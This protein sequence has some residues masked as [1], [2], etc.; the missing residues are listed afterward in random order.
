MARR[1]YTVFAEINNGIQRFKHQLGSEWSFVPDK[2]ICKQITMD[3]INKKLYVKGQEFQVKWS[4]K[5]VINYITILPRPDVKDYPTGKRLHSTPLFYVGQYSPHVSSSAYKTGR[6]HYIP[7]VN[8]TREM[9]AKYQQCENSHKTQEGH[10]PDGL[11][12]NGGMAATVECV[13]DVF[14]TLL[15]EFTLQTAYD[16]LL[17]VLLTDQYVNLDPAGI[18]AALLHIIIRGVA[19]TEQLR[20]YSAWRKIRD[21]RALM[22]LHVLFK[23]GGVN[24]CSHL[25]VSSLMHYMHAETSLHRKCVEQELKLLRIG[26]HHDHTKFQPLMRWYYAWYWGVYQQASEVNR[27]RMLSDK[28][29]T[30]EEVFEG[31]ETMFRGVGSSLAQGIAESPELRETVKSVAKDVISESTAQFR[32]DMRQEFNDIKSEAAELLS[33]SISDVKDISDETIAKSS[34]LVEK[35]TNSMDSITTMMDSIRNM[36]SGFLQNCMS[37]FKALP[38]MSDIKINL[39]SILAAIRDWIMYINVDSSVLKSILIISMLNNLG[40]LKSGFQ[41]IS[42]LWDYLKE[43]QTPTAEIDGEEVKAEETSFNAIFSFMSGSITNLIQVIAGTT[44][45]IVNGGLI[46]ATQFWS[47]CEHLS[48]SLKTVH[49]IGAGLMGFSRI[50]DFVSKI[51]TSVSDWI[52]R[53]LFKKTPE[54]EALARKVM[55]WVVKVKYFSTEAGLD[56]IRLNKKMR[57]TA[58]SLYAEYVAL[59]ISCRE[60]PEYR[61]LLSDIERHKKQIVDIYDYITR[62]E[63]VSNFCPTMFHIQFVGEPGVGKSFLFKTFVDNIAQTLWPEDVDSSFYSY[64]PNL[65]FF[66]GYAGQRIFYIDDCFRM[67][68]PKHLTQLIGLVTNTP[69]I[70]PMA[71]LADKG[72]QLTSDVMVS[73]TNTAWPIGKD[74]LCMEAVHRRRHMLVEVEIDPRVRDSSTGAFSMPLYKKYYKEEDLSK[75]PHLKFNMLRP[76]PKDLEGYNKYQTDSADTFEELKQFAEELKKANVRVMTPGAEKLS[77]DTDPQFFFS[78]DNK[79]PEGIKLPCTGWTYE[80]MIHNFIVRYRAFR[81]LERTYSTQR[82]YAHAERA[83]MEI[84]AALYQSEDI[85]T[86]DAV[87]LP[88][89]KLIEK[90]FSDVHHPYGVSDPIGQKIAE[91][92]ESDQVPDLDH[93]DFEKMVDE[94]LQEKKETMMSLDHETEVIRSIRNRVRRMKESEPVAMRNALRLI[95]IN[96]ENKSTTYMPLLSDYTVWD[97]YSHVS[98]RSKVGFF[99]RNWEAKQLIELYNTFMLDMSV[100]QNES[101]LK[102]FWQCK[103]A[104][105]KFQQEM[106]KFIYGSHSYYPDREEFG[107]KR[108][109]KTSFPLFFLQRLE[110][111]FGQW[112]LDVSDLDHFNKYKLEANIR[113][114][115]MAHVKS[116]EGWYKVPIDTAFLFSLSDCFRTFVR[117][118]YSLSEL[119]QDLIVQDAKWRNIYTGRYTFASIRES[120]SSTILSGCVRAAEYLLAPIH[121]LF[122]KAPFIIE[123]AAKTCLFAVAIW[124]LRSVAR[125]MCGTEET[126]KYL[127]RGPQSNI[128]YRGRT[129]AHTTT[130]SEQEAGNYLKKNIFQLTIAD[131][132]SGVQV[133]GLLFKQYIV[134]NAHAIRGFKDSDLV[135]TIHTPQTEEGEEESRKI[136]IIPR[137]NFYIHEDG[138]LA[139]G[140]SRQLPNK[141]DIF[142]QF[143]SDEEFDRMEFSNSD[144]LLL[145]R[146]QNQPA[147]EFHPF[148]K[149][150]LKPTLTIPKTQQKAVLD[151]ALILN[152]H[153]IVGKSG[154]TALFRNNQGNFRI[155]GIQAW[156]IGGQYQPQIAVQVITKELLQPL[157]DKIELDHKPIHREAEYHDN[158]T[159]DV[160]IPGAFT[161]KEFNNVIH[162]LPKNEAAGTVGETQF[163]GTPISSFMDQDGHTSLR[164]PAALNP[165]DIRLY[166]KAEH[167]LKHS[168]GKY[169]RGEIQPFPPSLLS[170]IRKGVGAWIRSKLDKDS[171]RRLEPH[172]IITGTREDGSNPMNLSSSPG[173]PFI[174][175]KKKKGKRDFF[176]IDDEG[177]VCF[178][179]HQTYLDYTKFASHLRQRKLPL[180]RAYDFPKD[181]L[182]PIS[183]A[184][185]TASSPPKTRT[186]TCMNMFHV[187]AWREVT[188]DFWASMHRAADGTFPFCPGINPEGPEWSAAFHYLNKHPNAIDFD[189]SNWDGFLPADLLYLAGDIVADVSELSQEDRN[190]VDSILFDVINC[191]IQ[192]DRYIYQKFRGMVSGFPGTAEM[193]TLVH[194]LLL[195]CIYLILTQDYPQYHSIEAFRYHVSF[196]VYGD[197]IIITFSDEIS[198]IFNGV[199]IAKTYME[200][201]YPVTSADKSQA[202]H[203]AK[204]LRDC[205]FLKSTWTRMFQGV[206]V[207]KMDIEVAYDL[208]YW[209]RAK[210]HPVQQF[211]IN[212]VDALRIVFGH[213]EKRFD[214]FVKQ[215]NG[216]LKRA[217]LEPV[218]YTYYDFYIDYVSRY[219]QISVW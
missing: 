143:M 158:I 9:I 132:S 29:T 63:A 21:Q 144:M 171:F 61:V 123:W 7:P 162:L 111:R 78:E 190:V 108:K 80:Q 215:L 68:E 96:E 179:D 218:L 161:S 192:Y 189:V 119:Q 172:E 74:V 54:I 166:N 34:T 38:G 214:A 156:S 98:S 124:A 125:L 1:K 69:V 139:V 126:S 44:A 198:S 142:N 199:S 52:S 60:K 203:A 207:R 186:V 66:D 107:D 136:F 49:F 173:I 148:V 95:T 129:T 18:Y 3:Y 16:K 208:L 70:L 169:F 118:F 39:D 216:W 30:V 159:P 85:D 167:P 163:T 146:F 200:I 33:K 89:T 181:E 25:M 155:A 110:K 121:F 196:L 50:F 100:N 219:Y 197:D 170:Y 56:A 113:Y 55:L 183:K 53:V 191:N 177:N 91:S 213:G 174:F 202:I 102:G 114:N 105:F 138:D 188:L 67:Q 106:I 92:P 154:S 131:S 112:A 81:G 157:L 135:V 82:K 10:H 62:L 178:F 104:G 116:G 165:L 141:R 5:E 64:N 101:F 204:S 160:Y 153:T 217:N 152:G 47:L 11:G 209:V 23:I 137:S 184:L 15:R 182:R 20:T 79:P 19:S 87:T 127:H 65:E 140:Y 72:T 133:Q 83:L 77:P 206:Y 90:W 180:T 4:R 2:S 149:V 147:M 187:M 41:F 84:D 14:S 115:P 185:G 76:V 212:V 43:L 175:N 205:Q 122:H 109:Q 22:R 48:K 58:T 194:W 150:A 36:A 168:L 46:T 71:N 151:R 86:V 51:F 31:Q 164:V 145:S 73:S 117:E 12:W 97:N 57:E 176:D 28:N 75:F 45:S 93:I 37:S 42:G 6:I 201:G 40:L 128:Q 88:K 195:L 35:L 211:Y 32:Q 94:I 13:F 59:S 210:E 99:K 120:C 27:Y 26:G 130:I 103:T 17:Q 193:N 8:S 134:I 24:P